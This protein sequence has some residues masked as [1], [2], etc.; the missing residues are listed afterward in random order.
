MGLLAAAGAEFR[1]CHRPLSTRLW[2]A[3]RT[4]VLIPHRSLCRHFSSFAQHDQYEPKLGPCEW[5]SI[6]ECTRAGLLGFR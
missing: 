5:R 3:Q 4:A 2:R 6:I 1:G